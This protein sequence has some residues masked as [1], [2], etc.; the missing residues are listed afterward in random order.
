MNYQSLRGIIYPYSIESGQNS[1]STNL[2]HIYASGMSPF[3][4]RW[5]EVHIEIFSNYNT[6]S[7]H[8]DSLL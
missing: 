7:E 4:N 6:I 2:E 8:I 1:A 3:I 5:N